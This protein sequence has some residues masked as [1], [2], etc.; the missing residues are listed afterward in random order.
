[1]VCFVFGAVLMVWY[2][3]FLELFSKYVM[4]WFWNCSHG[5][6]SFSFGAIL[7]VWYVVFQKTNITYHENSSKNKTYH[8][9]KTPP[10]TKYTIP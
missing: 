8:T 4:F 5:M 2:V 6:I 3:L 9:M 7:M 10:K 1:M